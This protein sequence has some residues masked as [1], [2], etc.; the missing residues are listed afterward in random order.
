MLKNLI[1][2]FATKSG[3]TVSIDGVTYSGNNIQIFGDGNIQIDGDIVGR[4]ENKQVNIHV[5]GDC[6]SIETASGNIGIGGNVHNNVESVSGDITIHG[7]VHGNVESV[8]GD[9]NCKSIVGKV[10]TVSGDIG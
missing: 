9:V 5:T 8:S 4:S 2:K 3:A 1:A 10:T 6:S 7:N